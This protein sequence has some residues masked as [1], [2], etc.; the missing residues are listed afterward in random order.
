[1]Y[2]EQTDL[3]ERSNALKAFC[4]CPFPGDPEP[5]LLDAQSNCEP[6]RNA[7]WEAL[8]NICHPSVRT[9]ALEQLS[10]STEKALPILILNYHPKDEIMLVELAKSIPVDFECNTNW[11]GIHG[12]I[13]G[14]KDH[15][16]KAPPAL[17]HH[18]YETT[19]CSCCREYALYQ[20]GKRRLLS[21]EILE[22]CILDSND[23][24]RKYAEK[25]LKRRQLK[26]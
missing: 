6:L 7:A 9:F 4:R 14:M 17:L 19:Y 8:E 3:I 24:I 20:M 2:L 11:H 12:D 22:E 16:L 25:F 10:D 23:D 18:I 15:K 1:M 21:A 26:R 13:L 5:I